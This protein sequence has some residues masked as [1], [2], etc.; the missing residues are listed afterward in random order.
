[1]A[2]VKDLGV[3]LRRLDYSETSQ[4]LV[5]FCRES[6]QQR[7]IARGVKRGTKKRVAVGVDL[8]EFG[9]VVYQRRPGSDAQLGTLTEWRQEDVFAGARRDLAT[10]YAVQYAAERTVQATEEADPHPTLFDALLALLRHANE[11]GTDKGDTAEGGTDKRLRM[12]GLLLDYLWTLLREIGLTPQLQRCAGCGG[13][14]APMYFSARQG[15]LL[16]RDCEPAYVEKRR[17]ASEA[18]VVLRALGGEA[19]TP[20]PAAEHGPS[21]LA[22]FDLLDYHLTEI[23]A[24][25]SRVAALLRSATA[26]TKKARAAGVTNEGRRDRTS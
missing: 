24:K 9:R 14:C 11:G 17:V 2:S 18:L 7:L 16:C 5:V 23:L 6:G 25:P 20:G 19:R 4:V 26:S 3:V 22:A 12:S 15:G 13:E 10:W 21:V 8:L 1:L